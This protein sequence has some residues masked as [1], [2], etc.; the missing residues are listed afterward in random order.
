MDLLA[1]FPYDRLFLE[2]ALGRA[3]GNLFAPS[4]GDPK[5]VF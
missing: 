3:E 2:D 5:T 1:D 4:T